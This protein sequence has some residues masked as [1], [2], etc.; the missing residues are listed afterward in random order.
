MNMIIRHRFMELEKSLLNLQQEANYRVI[1][2][3][4]NLANAESLADRVNKQLTE[5]QEELRG[6]SGDG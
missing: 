5:V 6:W 4:E 2:A 1:T 3:K